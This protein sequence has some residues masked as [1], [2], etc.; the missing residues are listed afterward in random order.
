M[1]IRL[2]PWRN[3]IDFGFDFEE[4]EPVGEP[5]IVLVNFGD[6][7]ATLGRPT[8]Q[9]AAAQGRTLSTSGSPGDRRVTMSPGGMYLR[10]AG[11]QTEAP[12]GCYRAAYA[13]PGIGG[14][15]GQEIVWIA[16]QYVRFYANEAAQLAAVLSDTISIKVYMSDDAPSLFDL[17]EVRESGVL[18]GF[19]NP[20]PF[21]SEI[22]AS[23]S[24]AHS[25]GNP[26]DSTGAVRRFHVQIPINVVTGEVGAYE[27]IGRVDI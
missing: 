1:A 13:L 16:V 7:F 21:N 10:Y 2:D 23:F 9:T 17:T 27:F 6:V 25:S 18:K 3:I 15:M 4:D 12:S 11:L 22:D 14:T 5:N 24:F 19:T 26:N 8:Q 20:N